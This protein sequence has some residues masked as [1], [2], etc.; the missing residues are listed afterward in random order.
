MLDALRDI[1]YVSV[2][3]LTVKTLEPDPR[4]SKKWTAAT[5]PLLV[6]LCALA[7]PHIA[8]A[9][10]VI[11]PAP[12]TPASQSGQGDVTI[13]TPNTATL[14]SAVAAFQAPPP[15]EVGPLTLLPHFLYRFVYGNGIQSQPGRP[16]TTAINSLS[17]GV[18]MEY[19]THWTLDYTP[20][21][22][23]YSNKVFRDTVDESANLVGATNY[24][25]GI[26]RFT[27]T[28]THTSEPLVETGMQTAETSYV[29]T[30]EV[31]HRYNGDL[32][33]D[34][35]LSQNSRY[36]QGFPNSKEWSILDWLRYKVTQ[37][38]DAALGVALGYVAT[39]DNINEFYIQPQVQV[40]L[41]A[42]D[43][44]TLAA[45]AGYE[46]RRIY[47]T[48][49]ASFNNPI[50]NASIQ[51]QPV[52]QTTFVLTAGQELDV[53]YFQNQT[54]RTTQ[55]DAKIEQR[56]LARYYLTAD[57]GEDKVDYLSSLSNLGAGRNDREF[58]FNIRL[59]TTIFERETLALFWQKSRNSSSVNTYAFSSSQVGFE[60]GYRY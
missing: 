22:N 27:E 32:A 33:M 58:S 6:L 9:Q 57:L 28:Y 41:R 47:G 17:P 35:G 36:T 38:L 59:S 50:Y 55:W 1:P 18:L 8:S 40:S 54:T 48:S 37:R 26:L 25:D 19:G 46:N 20:T 43:K 3:N 5:L 42:T 21:W 14:E 4:A 24:S 7:R 15:I 11:A 31:T 10:G 2:Q 49:G 52:K 30:F 23:I 44:I 60:L 53:A 12:S 56:L 34:L 51:Y 16:T 39:S 29:T 13:A 45:T